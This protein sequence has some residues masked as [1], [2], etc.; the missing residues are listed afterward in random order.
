MTTVIEM[1]KKI[2]LLKMSNY[3]NDLTVWNICI[4]LDNILKT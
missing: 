2:F 3:K 1:K 4:L